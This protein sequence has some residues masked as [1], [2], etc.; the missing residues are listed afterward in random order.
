M[1]MELYLDAQLVA[2]NSTRLTPGDLGR[3]RNNWLGRSQYTADPYF[4][5]L[6]D[7]FRIYNTALSE[8]QIRY[9]AGDR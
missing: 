1:N 7:D 6:V 4:N 5:G 9:I 8:G 3:T 2:S